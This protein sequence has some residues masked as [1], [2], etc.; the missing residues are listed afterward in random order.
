[1]SDLETI[2][3][4]SSLAKEMIGGGELGFAFPGALQAIRLCTE[5]GIAVLGIEIFR[6]V[7]GKF[8]TTKM[9]AYE[10]PF[11]QWRGYVA[12]NNSLA[13]E[14]VE[15]NPADEEHIYV[16]TASSWREFCEIQEARQGR[17]RG[18]G[19]A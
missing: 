9:S 16:L 5:N 17:A 7:G 4:I 3:S 8:L 13:E 14:F 18:P 19:L 2:N 10:L 11:N 12:A 1:M 15:S 6:V